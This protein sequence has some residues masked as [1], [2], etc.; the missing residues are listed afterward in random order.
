MFWAPFLGSLASG[1]IGSFLEKDS[2]VSSASLMTQG[3]KEL[4]N[5][6]IGQLKGGLGR[7]ATPS[8]LPAAAETPDLLTSAFD[9]SS[10]LFGT[11][12][13]TLIDA[14][15]R[16]AAGQP[17]YTFNAGAVTK[18]FNETYAQPLLSSWR[19]NVM[20]L[21]KESYNVPGLA[22]S[23]VTAR[24][25]TDAANRFYGESVAP[26]LFN[27]LQA[28]WMAGVQ[29]L[30]NAAGRQLQGAIALGELPSLASSGAYNMGQAQLSEEQRILSA[31]RGEES[32]L[33][34]ENNPYL[35]YA[36]GLSNQPTTENI[37][38]QGGST[39]LSDTAGFASK[40]LMGK[41]FGLFG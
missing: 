29:S 24:G 33:F 39:G 37:V 23:S 31:L 4:L 12:T 3:Q 32:R 2:D 11:G 30:E 18:R 19:Q 6:V 5:Q 15:T 17:A 36:L 38:E 35:K 21:V 27:A 40:L 7:G 9:L 13:D 25:V 14:L 26:Q 8:S 22:N 10:S 41:A 1:L 34:A 28:D 20:P 16:Q